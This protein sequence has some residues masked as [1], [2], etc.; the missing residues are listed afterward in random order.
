MA[1]REN[2][3]ILGT[4]SIHQLLISLFSPDPVLQGNSSWQREETKASLLDPAQLSSKGFGHIIHELKCQDWPEVCGL[5][6]KGKSLG[7]KRQNLALLRGLWQEW[8]PSS[9]VKFFPVSLLFLATE[10]FL[11]PIPLKDMSYSIARQPY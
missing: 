7:N 6:F 10:N 5:L 8:P 9:E 4:R 1:D 3:V 2:G 11:P